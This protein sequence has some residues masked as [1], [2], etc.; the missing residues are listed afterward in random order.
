LIYRW[1]R[2]SFYTMWWVV[3]EFWP[4]KC[5]PG[6]MAKNNN[7][8]YEKWINVYISKTAATITKT[9]EIFA[10]AT[11]CGLFKS[12][13]FILKWTDKEYCLSK[14]VELIKNLKKNKWYSRKNYMIF[15]AFLF[16]CCEAMACS[17]FLTRV[18]KIFISRYP[19]T[20]TSKIWV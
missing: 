6:D 7:K 17:R 8:I 19:P 4:L 3:P 1:F 10:Q 5:T 18:L 12:L 14:S 9:P 2:W 15:I 13:L 11:I 20:P 16:W